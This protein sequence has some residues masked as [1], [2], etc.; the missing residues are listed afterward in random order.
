LR[1]AKETADTRKV[2]NEL[3]VVWLATKRYGIKAIDEVTALL[4]FRRLE[5]SPRH[6]NPIAGRNTL[7]TVVDRVLPILEAGGVG[8]AAEEVDVMLAHK[9]SGTANRVQAI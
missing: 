9:E 1:I 6:M 4:E 5:E 8:F 2:G 3:G 7:G